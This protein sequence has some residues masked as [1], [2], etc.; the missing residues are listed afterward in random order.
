MDKE[1]IYTLLLNLKGMQA[2][3]NELEKKLQSK[4]EAY[5]KKLHEMF[6]KDRI[7]PI[8][9]IEWTLEELGE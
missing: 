8:D 9:A 2:E 4:S 3:I 1:Q 5:L 6:G 7:S